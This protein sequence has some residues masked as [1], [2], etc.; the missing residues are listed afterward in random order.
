MIAGAANFSLGKATCTANS[1]TTTD[2]LLPVNATPTGVLTGSNFTGTLQVLSTKGT[3]ATF[4]LSGIFYGTPATTTA[5][6]VPLSCAGNTIY[7]PTTAVTLTA[8]VGSSGSPTGTMTFFANGTQIGTPQTVANGSATLNYTFVTPGTY[9]IT[10]SYSGD[11]YFTASS[12]QSPTPVYSEN[13]NFGM[14]TV[15]FPG[16]QIFPGGTA[17]Y[18]FNLAQNVYTGTITFSLS[19]LPPNSSLS[20]SPSSVASTACTAG[21][22]VAFS[23]ITQQGTAVLPASFGIFGRGKGSAF[24]LLAVFALGFAILLGRRRTRLRFGRLWIVLALLGVASSLVACSS[25]VQTPAGT[26]AGPYTVTVTATGSTGATSTLT[27]PAF[28]VN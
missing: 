14:T 15:S 27:L 7:L 18:S 28:T 24:S 3:T 13:P 17:V 20:I 23:V 6:S 12:G 5:V 11:S 2:C 25:N 8:T 21:T 9:T 16:G 19:G 4:T 1:D 26:P 22:T 10:A